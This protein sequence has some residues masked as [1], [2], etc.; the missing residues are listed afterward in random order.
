V[1]QSNAVYTSKELR[2]MLDVGRDCFS[3]W[4]KDGLPVTRT[5]RGY[6]VIGEDLI[7]FLQARRESSPRAAE[8]PSAF[9]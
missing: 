8:Q 6:I 4:V 7:A 3:G 9:A 1:I 5:G 2:C